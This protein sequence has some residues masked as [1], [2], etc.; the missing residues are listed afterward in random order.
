MYRPTSKPKILQ[1][2]GG[3]PIVELRHFFTK[4]LN[5]KTGGEILKIRKI[6]AKNIKECQ[7][8]SVIVFLS[9]RALT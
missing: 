8:D 9:L 6:F 1:I 5:V 2:N 3:W 7:I 4:L